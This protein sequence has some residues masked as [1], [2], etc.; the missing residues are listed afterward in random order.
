MSFHSQSEK[1]IDV[2]IN[3]SL[4]FLDQCLNRTIL[5]ASFIKQINGT[6]DI[7]H[8]LPENIFSLFQS[9]RSSMQMLGL[10]RVIGSNGQYINPEDLFDDLPNDDCKLNKFFVSK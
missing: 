3:Y 7:V 2:I 5:T 6:E 1:I 8:I 4:I 9:F 10:E